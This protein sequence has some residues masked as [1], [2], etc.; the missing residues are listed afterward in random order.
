[1]S[2]IT[3]KFEEGKFNFR[4]AVIV[5]YNEKILVQEEI[6]D[7]NF[8]LPGR[9][10]IM[11]NTKDAIIREIEEELGIKVDKDNLKLVQ[12][13]EN[14]F[15]YL[16]NEKVKN[17]HE[18]SYIYNIV[19]DDSYDITKKESFTEL[20]KPHV[21]FVWKTKEEVLKEDFKLVPNIVKNVIGKR[22]LHY[23]I[24]DDRKYI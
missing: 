7:E 9:V 19:L 18:L 3:V 14:F 16:D 6:E 1:M 24:I 17:V 5:E 10:H 20:E 13:A 21:T 22:E 23:D 8:R 2:D 12:I 4:V 15:D 11:E